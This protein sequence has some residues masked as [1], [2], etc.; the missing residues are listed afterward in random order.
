[1]VCLF[2]DCNK[3]PVKDSVT[4]KQY[5][6]SLLRS[7]EKAKESSLLQGYK[8]HVTKSVKPEP[9]QMAGITIVL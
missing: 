5:K 8:I 3:F 1:M 2:I 9:S 6:F 4:E 7:L